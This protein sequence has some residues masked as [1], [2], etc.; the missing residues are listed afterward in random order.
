MYPQNSISKKKKTPD[1][2]SPWVNIR[3]ILIDYEDLPIMHTKLNQMANML[4]QIN[5]CKARVGLMKREI[6]MRAVLQFIAQLPP[7]LCYFTESEIWN[8]WAFHS[9][10]IS[11]GHFHN[12]TES[13]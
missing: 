7:V 5:V 10:D 11:R 4:Q 6:Q 1:K 13:S 12:F 8:S 9:S 2:Q 3:V